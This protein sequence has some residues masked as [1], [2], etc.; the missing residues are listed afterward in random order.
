MLERLA[1]RRRLRLRLDEREH[2]Y[3]S[4]AEF[5]FA[6]SSRTA[7]PALRLAELMHRPAAELVAESDTLRTLELKL[8]GIIE[9][10]LEHGISIAATLRQ[11]GVMMFSKDHGWR[12][13]FTSL[14]ETARG[15]EDYL[16]VALT[17]YVDYL[18]ARRD[19]LRTLVAL[20]AADTAAEARTTV[21]E[22]PPPAV[23]ETAITEPMRR[24]PHGRAVMLRLEEGREIAIR[25]ARHSFA[26]AHGR[27][28]ALV[29]DDG[30]RYTLRR[31][32][33]TIGRSRENDVKVNSTLRNISRRHLLLETV[34]PDAVMVT[35]LSSSGTFIPPAAI[36]S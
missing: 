25:L 14:L 2:L 12:A 7:V 28:W 16:R 21:F 36:A 23:S 15:H 24:L 34:G 30:Q 27:D 33:N 11:T 8:T 22:A 13:I 19:T 3:T 32:I 5:D 4:L 18:A 26:L 10:R 1:A 9:D 17:R 29:T 6:V 31:G 20:R 35:D